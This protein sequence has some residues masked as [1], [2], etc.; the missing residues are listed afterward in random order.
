MIFEAALQTFLLGSEPVTEIVRNRIFGLVREPSSELPA[1]LAQRIST[2]RQPTFCRTSKL[3]SADFQLD[4]YAMTGQDAWGL[5]AAVRSLMIDFEG[6]MGDIFVNKILLT[7]EFPTVDGDPGVIR[8]TQLY[9]IW[10]VE[11]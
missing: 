6:M 10:Y 2:V 8:V 5:A 11:D 7:N 1:L 9:N 3:V 4:A